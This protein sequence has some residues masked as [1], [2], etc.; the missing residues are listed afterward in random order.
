L[1][2]QSFSNANTPWDSNNVAVGY[3]ALFT[4]QPV[5]TSTG[6][7]NT[8]VGNVALTGNT[9]GNLNTAVGFSTLNTNLTGSNNTALGYNAGSLITGSQNIDI[10]HN[11]VGT[12]SGFIR[13]G[14]A[15]THIRTYIAGIRAV[16]TGLTDAVPVLIDSTGQLG[17]VNSSR[18]Y[19]EDIADM[20][21]ASARLQSLRPVTF[22]YKEANTSGEKPVQ[23]GLIAE[24]VA[25]TFPELAVF[26]ADGQPETVKYQDLV[27]LLLNEVQ[28]VQRR[29]DTLAKR[30]AELEARDRERAA[31]EQARE[32]RLTQLEKASTT[33]RPAP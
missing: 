19:K 22:R 28:K 11:G 8:A 26:N 29:A 12:D 33:A 23:F 10:G 30:L 6:G 3:R 9:T 7:A 4:N 27:P 24:E 32:A 14:T 15:G 16:A 17:T 18:R 31:H 13:I 2:T 20:G 5:N 25:E 21:N 1:Y